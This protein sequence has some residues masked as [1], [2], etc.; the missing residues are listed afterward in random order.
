ASST[1]SLTTLRCPACSVASRST[2][3]ETMRQGPH[4]GAQKSTTTGTEA[5]VSVP[6]ESLSASTSHGS[7]WPQ[8]AHWGTPCADAWTR[9]R[10]PQWGQVTIV[11]GMPPTDTRECPPCTSSSPAQRASSASASSLCC[12]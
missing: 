3:G 12:P 11:A 7:L 4:H 5:V 6:N 9:L 8:L 10:L 2:A 1:F